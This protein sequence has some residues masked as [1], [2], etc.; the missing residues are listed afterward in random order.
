LILKIIFIYTDQV[1]ESLLFE[2]DENRGHIVHP[3]LAAV[4]LGHQLV[5]ELVQDASEL[6][7][8]VADSLLDPLDHILVGLDLPDS[9]ASHNNEIYV[10]VLYFLDVRVGGDHLLLW[11]QVLILFVL[12][13]SEGPRQVQVPVDSAPADLPSSSLYSIGLLGVLRLVVETQRHA[14]AADAGH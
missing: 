1:R 3:V 4:V 2:L 14:L 5:Q 9:I 6:P 8:L 12:H 7:L 13:I 11:F 10:L